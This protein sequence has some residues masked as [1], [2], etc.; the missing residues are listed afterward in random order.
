MCRL[1][2]GAS[3]AIII[4]GPNDLETGQAPDEHVLVEQPVEA[5]RFLTLLAIRQLAGYSIRKEIF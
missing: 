2:T 3:L 4:F 1:A 5:G